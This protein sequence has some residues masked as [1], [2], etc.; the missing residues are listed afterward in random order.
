M[1]FTKSGRYRR[2][3]E[4]SISATA[5]LL[6]LFGVAPLLRRKGRAVVDNCV[7][8]VSRDTEMEGRSFA[9]A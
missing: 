9:S 4:I 2:V 7:I 3:I 6:I 5:L 1:V 8:W